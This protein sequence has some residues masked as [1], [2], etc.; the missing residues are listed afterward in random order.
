MD[1]EIFNG[2]TLEQGDI[3][4]FRAKSVP[5]PYVEAAVMGISEQGHLDTFSTLIAVFRHSG[6][7][8]SEDVSDLRVVTRAV[9]AIPLQSGDKGFAKNERVISSIQGIRRESRVVAAY[10]GIIA[11]LTK[12]GRFI[13]GGAAHFERATVTD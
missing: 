10:D 12:D 11:T 9:E 4:Q 3:I 1:P 8:S 13:S 2:V 5:L 6:V 7:F